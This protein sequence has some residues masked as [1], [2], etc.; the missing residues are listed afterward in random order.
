MLI[1]PDSLF[2]DTA[3]L[4]SWRNSQKDTIVSRSLIKLTLINKINNEGYAELYPEWSRNM[5]LSQ[6]LFE[7]TFDS[8]LRKLVKFDLLSPAG[9]SYTRRSIYGKY[10]LGKEFTLDE[11][12]IIEDLYSTI[13]NKWVKTDIDILCLLE[14]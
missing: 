5:H 10:K 6:S 1:L 11:W 9:R 13:P 12:K 3:I 8:R 4:M 2:I 14:K 7:V